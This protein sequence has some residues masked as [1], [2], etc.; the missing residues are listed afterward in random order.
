[1][2]LPALDSSALLSMTPRELD[3]LFR[4]SRAGEIPNGPALGVALVAA[5]T[6][7]APSIAGAINLVAW[8]GKTFDAATGTLHNRVSPMQIDAIRAKVYVGPSVLDGSECIVLD[9]SKTSS[10]AWWIR[11][12]IRNVAPQLYLGFAYWGRRRL[13]AFSLDFAVRYES[14]SDSTVARTS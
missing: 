7:F 5:G 12:E 2:N 4:S 9:Y 14:R 1:M 13:T 6:P 10:I 8:Q 11:D 3:A